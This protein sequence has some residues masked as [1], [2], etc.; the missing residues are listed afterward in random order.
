MFTL[1]KRIT[2]LNSKKLSTAHVGVLQDFAYRVLKAR[3]THHLARYDLTSSQWAVLGMLHEK[4]EGMR[5]RD[6]AEVLGVKKP[7][8]TA[9][10]QKLQKRGMIEILPS[11]ADGRVRQITLSATS[12]ALVPEIERDLRSAMHGLVEGVSPR[13]LLGYLRVIKAIS[14]KGKVLEQDMQQST[15]E[16]R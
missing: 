5:A 8:I 13:D 1:I 3:T 4:R 10:T 14:R 7:Y 12:V 11:T 2:A 15:G 6:L 9:M 16:D